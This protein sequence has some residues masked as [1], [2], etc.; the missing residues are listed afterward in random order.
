MTGTGAENIGIALREMV[1][2]SPSQEAIMAEDLSLSRQK[3]WQ[4]VNS[5]AHCFQENG[6]AQGD[7]VSIDTDDAIVSI[8]SV[9][10]LAL[11]GAAYVP[12][13]PDLPELGFGAAR[14]AFR[15]AEQPLPS[16][17]ETRIIDHTWSPKFRDTDKDSDIFAGYAPAVDTAWILSSSGTTGMPKY[18]AL[19]ADLLMRRIQA[20]GEDFEA[21]ETRLLLL[22]N[23]MSRPFIIRAIAALLHGHVVVDTRSLGF[24]AVARVNLICASPQQI[25]L[26]LSGHVLSPKIARLQLSGAPVTEAEILTL[27]DSFNC[28]EDVYGANETIKSR[29]IAYTRV[30]GRLHKTQKPVGSIIEVVTPDGTPCDAGQKGLVRVKTPWMVDSY[31]NAPDAS[32]KSFRDGWFY[33]GDMAVKH[34][35]GTLDF[36]GRASDIVNIGGQKILLSD[37]D[38]QL[39]NAPDIITAASFPNPI[40]GHEGRLAAIL[41]VEENK[42]L[43]PTID[44]AWKTCVERFGAYQAPTV[45]LVAPNLPH[46][47]DGG[48][49]R[50]KAMALFA[51]TIRQGDPATVNACLF[52][53]EVNYDE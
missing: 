31:L 20:I 41:Q 40:E 21:E 19:S 53:F 52:I 45:M 17:I 43:H 35:D 50:K 9:F 37:V 29:I 42:G 32:R 15:T 23:C 6:V 26:G 24:C 3:L 47:A 12:F 16:G 2:K 27:L 36:L 10:A 49:Q 8:A 25:R 38:T 5:Y 13:S 44:A 14:H 48:V 39:C 1:A 33:P 22:F 11:I 4:V 34:A 18:S 46:A 7:L 28:V 30:G 51:E